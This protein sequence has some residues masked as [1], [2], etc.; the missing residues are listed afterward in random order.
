MGEMS[1]VRTADH[2][3]S[4]RSFVDSFVFPSF[5]SPI[6]PTALLQDRRGVGKRPIRNR[7]RWSVSYAIA[8]INRSSYFAYEVVILR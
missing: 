5:E 2:R 6:L 4:F 8:R 1:T 3:S 7:K